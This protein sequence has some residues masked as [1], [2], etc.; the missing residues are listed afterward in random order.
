VWQLHVKC[1]VNLPK[2]IAECTFF[3]DT[4]TVHLPDAVTLG[5]AYDGGGAFPTGLHGHETC[6]IHTWA[7]LKDECWFKLRSI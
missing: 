6:C 1:Y 5:G 3:S 4:Y 2:I 7:V